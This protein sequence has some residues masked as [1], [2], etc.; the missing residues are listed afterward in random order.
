MILSADLPD[1]GWIGVRGTV[2]AATSA[3]PL[4]S[5]ASRLETLTSSMTGYARGVALGA[6][7]LTAVDVCI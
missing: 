3:V 6:R 5:E 1:A 2:G 4:I 7:P